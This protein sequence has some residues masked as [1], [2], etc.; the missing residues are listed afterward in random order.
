MNPTKMINS[1]MVYNVNLPK[2][3]RHLKQS[4][5][6]RNIKFALTEND[7]RDLSFPL[8]CPILNEPLDYTIR[9]Y[10]PW[11]P[12]VD[13]IDSSKGYEANNIQILSFKANRAKNDLTDAELKLF[14]I[15]YN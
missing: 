7:L 13:R 5:K 15:Y 11:K 10:S 14:S 1:V 4:A 6:K 9:S 12:S 3:L 8:T 2:L